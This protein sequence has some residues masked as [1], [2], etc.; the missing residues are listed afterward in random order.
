MGS[1]EMKLSKAYRYLIFDFDGTVNNTAPGIFATF[2]EVLAHFGVDAAAV[3]LSRHI[4]PPLVES[5]TQLVGAE[6][7]SEAIELHKQV[8]A[9]N[10]AAENS[11]LYPGIREALEA[12]QSSGYTLAIASCKYQPHAEQSLRFHKLEGYF[13]AVYGQTDGRSTKSEVLRQLVRDEGWDPSLCLMIGDTLHDLGGARACGIDAMA[14][15]Y[16]FGKE[17]ELAAF[18]PVAMAS[19][20]REIA[21]LLL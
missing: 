4:G 13:A 9:R 11:F 18:G 7:C 16:G 15:T 1:I 6:R 19:S 3:D 2:T 17:Q 10:H 21:E 12:L 8:Y 14:V 20:P 5:Y